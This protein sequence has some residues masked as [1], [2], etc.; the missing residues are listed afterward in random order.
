LK[1]ELYHY[2]TQNMYAVDTRHYTH[3]LDDTLLKID[4]ADRSSYFFF[5]FIIKNITLCIIQYNIVLYAETRSRN[6]TEK[7]K[8]SVHQT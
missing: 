5:Q 1:R 2:N 6:N 3:G 4:A 7:D 8:R